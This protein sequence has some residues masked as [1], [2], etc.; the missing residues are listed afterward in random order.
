MKFH[1]RASA[2]KKREKKESKEKNAT[3][4]GVMGGDS[5]VLRLEGDSCLVR[6][7]DSTACNGIDASVTASASVN[8][9]CTTSY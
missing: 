4:E 3:R 9:V 2:Q 1:P 6:N 5:D 8:T 7:E